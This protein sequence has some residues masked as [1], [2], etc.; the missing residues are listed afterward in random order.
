M[1]AYLSP[2]FHE[3]VPPEATQIRPGEEN[4]PEAAAEDV[5]EDEELDPV[6]RAALEAMM[7]D[8]DEDYFDMDPVQHAAL[9]QMIEDEA[10]IYDD[11]GL[12]DDQDEHG[13]DHLYNLPR[14]LEPR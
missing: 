3:P 10:R 7:E 2:L 5:A 1:L 11:V 12:R 4:E 14:A 9:E 8:E 13:G 6:Q